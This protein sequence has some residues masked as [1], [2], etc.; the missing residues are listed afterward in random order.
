MKH[1]F[2]S[3]TKTR[4]WLL[5][6]PV[7]MA[8]VLVSLI[9]IAPQRASAVE[10]ETYGPACGK[11]IVDGQVQALEWQDAYSQTIQ[12]HSGGVPEPFTAT[13]RVMNTANNLYLGITI[14]DDEFTFQAQYLPRGDGFRID[15]DND[16]SLTLFTMDDD[17]LNANAGFPQFRDSYI[18]GTPSPSTSAEDVHD[19]GTEDGDGAAWRYV[20]LNHFEIKHPLCSGDK[21]DFCLFPDDKVG[22]R[23]EYFDAKGD[24]S[25]GGS[26]L[27]PGSS[28][29]DQ[30]DIEI[31]VCNIPDLYIYLP[32]TIYD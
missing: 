26:F 9:M 30:A 25:F 20:D 17:V 24:G 13:V 32:L 31:S 29:T 6:L 5:V 22:F 21:K 4:V 23:L 28:A 8:I 11:P 1:N 12:L 18:T 2:N 14:N 3:V 7:F 16:N 15:F 19:G 10:R 27:Y